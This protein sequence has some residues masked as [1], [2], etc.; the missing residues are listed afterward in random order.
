MSKRHLS[1]AAQSAIIERAGRRCEYCQSQMEYSGQSF[2]FD[3]IAPISRAGETSLENLALACGGCNRHK[4][5]KV[6][7]TDPA[8]G[9]MIELFNPRQQQWETH[10]GWTD[11]YTQMIG[12]TA[13]GR[14]TVAALKLNRM[15]LVN[16]RRV[17]CMAGKHPA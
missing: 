1:S 8:T 17:L 12:L 7:G 3:H 5:N 11:D 6:Q 15:G 9:D 13:I 16:M 4:S 2:E 14:A 10:F